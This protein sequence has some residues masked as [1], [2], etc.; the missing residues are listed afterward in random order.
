L[1]ATQKNSKNREIRQ[2]DRQKDRQMYRYVLHNTSYVI[3]ETIFTTNQLAGVKTKSAQ[4][5]SWPVLVNNIKQQPN[6]NTNNLNNM[7]K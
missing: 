5:T 2:I 1:S 7:Y 3:S 4:P 6:Y